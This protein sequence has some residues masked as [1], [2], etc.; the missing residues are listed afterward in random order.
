MALSSK[1]SNKLTLPLKI[2]KSSKEPKKP[3]SDDPG[4]RFCIKSHFVRMSTVKT[5]CVFTMEAGQYQ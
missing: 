2:E 1:L 3:L 4:R 5:Y